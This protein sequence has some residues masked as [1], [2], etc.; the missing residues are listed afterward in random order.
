MR[1]GVIDVGTNSCR[2]LAVDCRGSDIEEIK[3]DIIITRLGEGV[4]QNAYLLDTAIERTR[5]AIC[6]FVNEMN[7]IGVEE[8]RIKGTSALRDV[9]NA[10]VLVQKV[11]EE[12]GCTLNIISGREEARLSYLGVGASDSNGLIIDIGGGSTEF[13]WQDNQEIKF[14]SLNI[15]AV[16]LTERFIS[17]P[18]ERVSTMEISFIEREVKGLIEREIAPA[19]IDKVVGLGGTITTIAAVEQ[20]MDEYDITKIDGYKLNITDLKKTLNRL[21]K[22][23]LKERKEV[24]GLQEERADIIISGIVILSVIMETLNLKILYVSEHDLLY[25]TVKDMIM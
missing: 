22:M 12:T 20:K 7:I 4:D 17:N 10:E 13:I 11:K 6:F 5:S 23:N 9:N 14:K 3:R 24:K 19:Y 25:G 16:R 2:M 21:R 8:I 18:Q 15:G 1:V